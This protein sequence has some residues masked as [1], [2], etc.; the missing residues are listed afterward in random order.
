MREADTQTEMV[1]NCRFR[2]TMV[3]V[4]GSEEL[5]VTDQ[6][7]CK[8]PAGSPAFGFVLILSINSLTV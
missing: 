1:T 8:G 4:L 7:S 2:G 5:L 6:V 3:N